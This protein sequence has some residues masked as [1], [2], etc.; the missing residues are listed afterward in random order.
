MFY[1]GD[2]RFGLKGHRDIVAPTHSYCN[3]GPL[4]STL[5]SRVLAS[6]YN[7][8]PHLTNL[9]LLLTLLDTLDGVRVLELM[10]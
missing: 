2:K 10:D 3:P 6:V 7:S 9:M 4:L 1:L 5:D 8:G